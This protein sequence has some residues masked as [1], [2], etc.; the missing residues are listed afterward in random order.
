MSE[1]LRSLPPFNRISDDVLR[2]I[3]PLVGEEHFKAEGVI[4]EEGSSGDSFYI[5]KSGEVEIR[6][7]I[8]RKEGRHK[9]IAVLDRGDF[10]GEMAVFLGQSRS[11]E[12]V[13][14]TDVTLITV[15]K[16]DFSA[17]FSKS[18]DA[19]F[20]VM[21]FF[22]AVLM[23]RLRST[24]DELVT[25]YETG[26]LAAAARSLP[27][28]SGCV[29]EKVFNVIK[30]EAGLFVVWNNFNREFEVCGQRGFNIPA[31]ESMPEDDAL[32]R[33]LITKRE[34]FL[35]FDL[36]NEGRILVSP[37]SIYNGCSMAASPFLSHERLSGFILLLDRT[38]PNAFSY[39]HMILLSAISGYVS[40]A[41][42]NLQYMQ[43]AVDRTRLSQAKATIPM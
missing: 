19:A 41:L 36:K 7:M 27:E 34:P 39:Q 17:L 22:T 24:T 30:P 20:K 42:E 9:L 40:V 43:E 18:P 26:R 15:S 14:K 25:V 13:A 35:S 23:D 37:D 28:L 32:I 38:K 31:G 4:F 16:K 5:I 11:A 12:A 33:W 1:N 8:D 10:F 3:T 6:K 21:E 2:I 29:M